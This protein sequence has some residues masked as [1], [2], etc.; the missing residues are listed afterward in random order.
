M[1]CNFESLLDVKVF[2]LKVLDL[3]ANKSTVELTKKS[4]SRSAKQNRSLHLY[5]TLISDQLNDMGLEFNYQGL[6][7]MDLSVR[8]TPEIVKTFIW[9]PIQ[10]AMFNIE[11]TTK[12]NTIQINEI[13]DVLTVYFGDKGILIEFPS[14]ESLENKLK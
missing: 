13:L 1:I 6:K 7:G 14:L 8:H 3:K 11:S 9:K 2:D 5:F 10:Y 4:N 12:I